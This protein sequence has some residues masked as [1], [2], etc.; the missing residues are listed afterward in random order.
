MISYKS[1]SDSK[2][3]QVSRTHHS[4]LVDLINVVV[5]MLST[6]PLISVFSSPFNNPLVIVS[7]SPIQ[8]GI[9]ITFIFQFFQFS[10]KVHVLIVLLFVFFFFVCLFLF[11]FFQFYSVISQFGKFSFSFF[12][13]SFFFCWLLLCLVVWTRLHDLFVSQ[14]PTKVCAFH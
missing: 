8:I 3:P 4:I 11:A 7:R 13:L 1:F 14:I 2:S 10:R 12:F 6:C 5:W 9:N